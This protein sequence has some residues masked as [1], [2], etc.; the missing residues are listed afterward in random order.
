MLNLF[1]RGSA[2]TAAAPGP[3]ARFRHS[4]QVTSTREGDRTVLLDHRGGAYFGLDEVGTRLWELLGGG[5]SLNEVAGAL[6]A[7]YDAPADVL[8][9]DTIELV[10]RLRAAGLVVEG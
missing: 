7:E 6:A 2:A 1:R 5:S 3:E 4:P 8:R 10:S 9:R